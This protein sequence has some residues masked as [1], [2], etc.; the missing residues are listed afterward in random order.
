MF[1][2]Y[3]V[4]N[5]NDEIDAVPVTGCNNEAIVRILKGVE[6]HCLGE[7]IRASLPSISNQIEQSLKQPFEVFA[8]LASST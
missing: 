8:S 5:G 1:W 3:L 6:N 4:G 7:A 2:L